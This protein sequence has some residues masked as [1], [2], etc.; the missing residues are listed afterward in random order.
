MFHHYF[1]CTW[2]CAAPSTQD[3]KVPIGNVWLLRRNIEMFFTREVKQ[4]QLNRFDSANFPFNWMTD[5]IWVEIECLK[6]LITKCY[7]KIFI[8]IPRACWSS[9]R[10]RTIIHPNVKKAKYNPAQTLPTHIHTHVLTFFMFRLL[11]LLLLLAN[12][13]HSLSSSFTY[14]IIA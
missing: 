12:A 4:Q 9:K 1:V 13:A 11:S 7:K 14:T 6:I 5:W 2:L 3:V 10:R 8:A